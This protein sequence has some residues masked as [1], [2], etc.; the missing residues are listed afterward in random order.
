MSPF[1]N[2]ALGWCIHRRCP[3][4]QAKTQLLLIV[5]HPRLQRLSTSVSAVLAMHMSGRGLPW[6]NCST[7]IKAC[8]HY[9]PLKVGCFK[10]T[11]S[12]Q[13]LPIFQGETTLLTCWVNHDSPAMVMS[14]RTATSY[15]GAPLM[16]KPD[17]V[18]QCG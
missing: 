13:K 11:V 16:D 18:E 6:G 12:P 17:D 3:R 14:I 2:M 4:S 8:V 9:G 10:G 1:E 7:A 5:S 15:G